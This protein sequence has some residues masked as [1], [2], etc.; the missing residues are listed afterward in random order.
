MCTYNHVILNQQK[1]NSLIIN[2][3]KRRLLLL[4]IFFISGKNN[5]YQSIFISYS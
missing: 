2:I 3:L 4:I 1:F 5:A